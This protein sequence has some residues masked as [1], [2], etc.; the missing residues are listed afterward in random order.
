MHTPSKQHPVNQ[1]RTSYSIVVP[2]WNESEHISHT[3]SAINRAV[4]EQKHPASTIVVDNNSTDNTAEIAALAGATV[5]FEPINQ[6]AR[7]R[8]AGANACNSDWIIFV[9]ADSTVNPTLLKLTLD[10]LASGNVIGGGSIVKFDRELKGIAKL[11]LSL[12]N[13]WSVKSRSAAGCYL[14]CTREAF[15]TV[16]G[17]DEKQYAAEELYLSKKLRKLATARDQQFLIHT[18]APIVSSARKIDWYTTRQM[19]EQ[20]LKLLIPGATKSRDKCT[21]WYDRSNIKNDK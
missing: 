12:W 5:V 4:S 10:A 3:L 11:T 13:W 21:V 15:E 9:D 2:A 16:G 20:V 18:E 17:F 6:I 1:A 19:F 7:A 14:Y 8:N